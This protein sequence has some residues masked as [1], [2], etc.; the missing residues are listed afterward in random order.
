MPDADPL[1]HE[2]LLERRIDGVRTERK[3]RRASRPRQLAGGAAMMG[4]IGLGLQ[5]VFQPKDEEGIVLEVDATEPLDDRWVTY[6][7]DSVSPSRS[8]ALVRPWLAPAG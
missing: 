3:V 1:A 2:E 6:E 5:E 4:A 8:R 7:H